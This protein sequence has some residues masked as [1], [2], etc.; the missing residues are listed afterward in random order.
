MRKHCKRVPRPISTLL[1]PN[2]HAELMLPPRLHLEMMLTHAANLDFQQSVL[3]V[4]NLAVG[5][6]YLQNKPQIQT[7]FETAQRIMV[8]LIRGVRRPGQEESAILLKSFN[9]ADRY[10][11]VQSRTNLVRA[12]DL[13]NRAIASDE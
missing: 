7:Q 1:T 3:G 8:Q 5:L 10:F 11:G 2:Q 4:F 9:L 6:S 13:L 12:Y